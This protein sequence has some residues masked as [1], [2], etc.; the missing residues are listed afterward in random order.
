MFI[1]I[2]V[3]QRTLQSDVCQLTCIPCDNWNQIE[4]RTRTSGGNN[5]DDDNQDGD[6]PS[7]MF[8]E[9]SNR[10]KTKKVDSKKKPA[11][12]KKIDIHATQ[13]FK[14]QEGTEGKCVAGSVLTRAQAKK[15]DKIPRLKV[16]EAVS[17][18]TR[19]P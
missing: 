18:S 2:P 4:A 17:M 19:L 12:L 15:S 16:K 1:W 11:Q 14:V 5:N 6:M 13:D 9:V 3:L 10:G 7:W 8:K